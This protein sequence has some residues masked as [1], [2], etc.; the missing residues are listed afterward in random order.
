MDVQPNDNKRI[1]NDDLLEK[2]KDIELLYDDVIKYY[3]ASVWRSTKTTTNKG[4]S[5]L[6]C[7]LKKH[8]YKL[9]Y[10]YVYTKI[11]NKDS[12][13]QEYFITSL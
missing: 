2:S 4:L 11:N 12:A 10:K 9:S 13:I 3:S 1:K 8:N 5:L 6:R 7:I